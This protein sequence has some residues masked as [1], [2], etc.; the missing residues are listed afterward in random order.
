LLPKKKVGEPW[1]ARS[2]TFKWHWRAVPG[3]QAGLDAQPHWCLAA[4]G[5]VSMRTRSAERALLCRLRSS[6]GRGNIG[7][8]GCLVTRDR[9]WWLSTRA[10]AEIA[11]V[12]PE[13]RRNCISLVHSAPGILEPLLKLG[14]GASPP[15]RV[16]GLGTLTRADS[17]DVSPASRPSRRATGLGRYA[18]T[19]KTWRQRSR[20]AV[21]K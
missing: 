1:V 12:S 16:K 11:P 15:L 18:S 7:G 21:S 20:S 5:G 3:A 14:C 9:C 8:V 10:T 19:A 2:I 17:V 4:N 13:C 6:R